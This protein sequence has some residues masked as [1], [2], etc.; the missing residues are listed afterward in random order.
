M[1]YVLYDI[2][3]LY[4][5]YDYVVYNKHILKNIYNRI[6]SFVFEAHPFSNGLSKYYMKTFTLANQSETFS[7][8]TG[9]NGEGK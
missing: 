2:Y 6:T 3:A 5:I 4:I 7:G 9:E 8:F 1:Q